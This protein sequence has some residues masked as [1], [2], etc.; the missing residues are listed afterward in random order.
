MNC[1]EALKLFYDIIDK[2][3]SD[4]DTE[5]VKKHL[6]GCS[7]CFSKFQLESS[8]H[9]FI[10]AKVSDSNDAP[11]RLDDLR[12]KICSK[13]DAVDCEGGK[14]GDRPSFRVIGMTLAAAATLV[15]MVAA[16]YFVGDLVRHS[17]EYL[18]LE[19]AH[20]SASENPSVYATSNPTSALLASVHDNFAYSLQ[21]IVNGYKMV[22]GT[23]EEI[24]GV[25]MS[26]FVYTNNGSTVSVFVIPS[27]QFE[28]PDDL[29]K[30]PISKDNLTLFDHHC[31]GCRLVYQETDKAIIVTASEDRSIDLLGFI[32]GSTAI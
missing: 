11:A 7:D 8:V 26:H 19:Q 30:N 20:F 18:P 32:P 12:A 13:L 22:G 27:D 4:I 15:I 2:E 9:A 10:S 1:Q 25:Q 3:A 21:P 31:H 14:S 24:M 16:A 6:A 29:K 28:I 17:R 23:T 5:E